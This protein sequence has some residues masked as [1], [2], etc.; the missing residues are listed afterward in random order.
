M[1]KYGEVAEKLRIAIEDG[2]YAAGDRLPTTPELCEIYGVSN[3]TIKKAIDELDRLGLVARRR[4]SGIY[5]KSVSPLRS[6]FQNGLSTSGQMAGFTAEHAEAGCTVGSEVHEFTVV[7]PSDVVAETLDIRQEE[8]VYYICRTRLVDG[9]P[10][11]VEYTYMPVTLVPG[12][13]EEHLHGSIYGYLEQE[14]GL[15]IGSSHRVLRAVLPTDDEKVWLQLKPGEPLFEVRQV[16]YLDDG[17]PFEYSTS[18]HISDYEFYV[19]STH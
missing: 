10:H 18:R 5:V 9:K 11:N 1:S 13:L 6:S 3:T 12:L 19:V 2:T 8:F 17:T 16:A 7:H 4:G 15:K 14:L